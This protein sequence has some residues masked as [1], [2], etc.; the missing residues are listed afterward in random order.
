MA[1]AIRSASDVSDFRR[2]RNLFLEYE[3]DLPPHLRHGAVPALSELIEKYADKSRAFLAFAQ[4]RA[5]GCVALREF[6]GQSA[7][8]ARLYVTASHRGRGAARALVQAAIAFAN[9]RAYR[10]IVL[11]T[12]KEALEPAYRLY[13]ALGFRECAPFDTVTY[14]CP[15][16]MELRLN[17][18]DDRI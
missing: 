9:S 4:E 15:T 11:D 12:N 18:A 14:E 10:R 17:L 8:L 16:F 3:L 2:L 5:I 1:V 13:R 7:L 6:D